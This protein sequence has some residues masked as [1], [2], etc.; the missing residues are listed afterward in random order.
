MTDLPFDPR[1]AMGRDAHIPLDEAKEGWRAWIVDRELPRY[2]NP[3]K[4]RSI[5]AGSGWTSRTASVQSGVWTDPERYF[6]VP[7]RTAHAECAKGCEQIDIPRLSCTC[8][9][10][11]AKT[12]E[13]LLD[14]LD[15]AY[16]DPDTAQ[17][18]VRVIGTVAN[19]GRV[20]EGSQGWRA[21]KS[22]PT[23]LW[24]PY[25]ASHLVKPLKEAYGC[26]VGLKNFV[27]ES[28]KEND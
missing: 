25:S 11:S 7:R 27:Q 15:Y 1:K 20:I 14:E 17:D 2:G 3:P 18:T 9:F 23:Q 19:W 26:P 13:Q 12:S 24:V 6:W 21:S 16:F 5:N 4:L 28:L 22:Y 8:G 10:Y